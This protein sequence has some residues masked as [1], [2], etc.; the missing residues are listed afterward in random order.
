MTEFDYRVEA[1]SLATV[2]RHMDNS[3]Y[4]NKIRIPEP[5]TNLCTKECLIME[6]LH[7]KKLSDAIEDELAA[8]LG[9]DRTKAEAL[10]KAKQMELILGRDKME[11]L[12]QTTVRSLKESMS[13]LGI[14]SKLRLLGL[15]RK[16]KNY[17]DLLVDVQ[18]HQLLFNGIFNGDPHPGT[19]SLRN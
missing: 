1:N 4:K 19:L 7:G 14:L 2:G 6:M 17:I 11:A 12:G 16:T 3:P 13:E 9:G 5:F 10:I 8:V 18:G 15:Y